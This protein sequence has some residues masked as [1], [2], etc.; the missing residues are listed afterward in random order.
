MLKRG[1]A[2]RT[3]KQTV[4]VVAM[5]L[6]AE[7]RDSLMVGGR[8]KVN[9]ARHMTRQ[10]LPAAEP[11]AAMSPAVIARIREALPPVYRIGVDLMYGAGLRLAEA[12]G[13][14]EDRVL[15][16]SSAVR[17]D[18]QWSEFGEGSTGDDG[19]TG[20]APTKHESDR[21]VPV[22][23]ALLDALATH[24]A[25]HGLSAEGT[26]MH[27]GRN[28]RPMTQRT[29]R[30]AWQA[31]LKVAAIDGTW[32][33]HDMRHAFGSFHYNIGGEEVATVA[34]WMGHTPETFIRT[35]LHASSATKRPTRD[36]LAFETCTE[37]VH[38]DG[39]EGITAGQGHET[40][41]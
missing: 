12:I 14:S 23:A 35:Y 31:A 26:F 8:L 18:R 25:R 39:P 20:F 32:T 27:S 13:L 11:T 5:A 37:R 15:R 16:V 3:V 1:L 21:T 38:T 10:T 17:V 4:G 30:R 41:R 2:P 19:V 22:S 7:L 29:W 33:A 34:A 36:P 6:D 28:G 9:P 40:A 24:K